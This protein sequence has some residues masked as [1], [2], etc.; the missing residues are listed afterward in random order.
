MA[1]SGTTAFTLTAREVII[2]ALRKINILSGNS[3]DTPPEDS[4]RARIE[5]NLMLKGMQRF[6][7]L[8]RL[9]DGSQALTSATAS[10]TLTSTLPYRIASCRYRNASGI[11]MPMVGLT[12][13]EYDDL[14]M[15]ASTGLPTQFYF[16]AQR[17]AGVLTTWPVLSVATTET[18]RFT[19]QRR[20]EDVSDLTQTIDCPP[21][22][23]E[24]IGYNLGAR[25]A[26]DY[27][28]VGPNIDR[29]IARAE[30]MKAELSD[31]ERP[32]VIRFLP[33]ATYG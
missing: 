19:Y 28:Q 20:F 9:T 3:A 27:G 33:M 7:S 30:Q 23:L 6:P 14:P 5:L 13:Q 31:A 22:A 24:V 32:D 8:W 12:R 25:L 16:D 1:T 18:L 21:E 17:D 10:Y 29:V 11:D 26:D 2:F 4:E 15:K